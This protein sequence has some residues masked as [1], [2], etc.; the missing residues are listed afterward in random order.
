MEQ[1]DFIQFGGWTKRY[2]GVPL[3]NEQTNSQHLFGVAHLCAIMAG[4]YENMGGEALTVSLL[5]AAL[6]SDLPEWITGDMPAPSKR[7]FPWPVMMTNG[8]DTGAAVCLRTAWNIRDQ[9]LLAEIELDWESMLGPKQLR[10]L[11]LADAMEGC[12]HCIKERM[13]GNKFIETRCY[14]H[15]RQ[16]IRDVLGDSNPSRAEARL[17]NHIDEMWEQANG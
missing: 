15:F 7:S 14:V 17:I 6:C 9:A 10:W 13:M 16:Y 11:K 2:H 4:D 1:I 5:M 8:T 12:F 3:I